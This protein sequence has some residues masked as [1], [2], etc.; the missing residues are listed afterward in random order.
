MLVDIDFIGEISYFFL[1]NSLSF[2]EKCDTLVFR[3][4]Y[5]LHDSFLFLNGFLSE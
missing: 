3:K 5:V 1:G 2:S 4:F